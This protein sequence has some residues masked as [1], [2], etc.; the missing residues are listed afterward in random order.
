[1]P[2]PIGGPLE[3][4]LYLGRFPNFLAPYLVTY[5]ESSLRMRGESTS[6]E[7]FC[8]KTV[9]YC[10]NQIP[11]FNITRKMMLTLFIEPISLI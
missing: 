1:M 5:A 2:L 10:Y 3:S 9:Q 8:V 6:F 11:T 4:S 7:P